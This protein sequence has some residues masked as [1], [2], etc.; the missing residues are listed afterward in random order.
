MKK[1]CRNA[2]ICVLERRRS[3]LNC[4]FSL[5]VWILN[6]RRV[7]E[8]DCHGMY[9]DDMKISSSLYVSWDYC[10]ITVK[11]KMNW[12][13][14]EFAIPFLSIIYCKSLYLNFFSLQFWQALNNLYPT[15]FIRWQEESPIYR[16]GRI[17]WKFRDGMH[18]RGWGWWN[19]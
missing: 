15:V 19:F 12:L 7:S 17:K 11:T 16:E 8:W 5:N 18:M 10:L 1:L 4:N 13:D 14:V 3:D 9:G 2:W 6:T